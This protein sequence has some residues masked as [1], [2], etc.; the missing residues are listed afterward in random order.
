MKIIKYPQ[1]KLKINVTRDM[2]NC[3]IFIRYNTKNN[4]QYIEWFLPDELQSVLKQEKRKRQR[5][6]IMAKYVRETFKNKKTIIQNNVKKAEKE[7]KSKEKRYFDLIN[8]I[9]QGHHWPKGNYVGFASIFT[10]Y[11]RNIAEKT[12]FLPGLRYS[13]GTPPAS[14]VIGHEML[15][16][17]FFD[18]IDKHYGLKFYRKIK[19]KSRDYLWEISEV[20]NS[21][22]ENWDPYYKIIQFKTPPYVGKDYYKKMKQ[23]WLKNENI[24]DLLKSWIGHKTTSR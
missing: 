14:Y 18:Y 24:D 17:M 15:H 16:F 3:R 9:F 11:P 6:D 13:K 4:P 2:E 23:Q 20:F 7:W 21:V 22:I 10:M 12:F 5:E 8:K 1:I 19:G